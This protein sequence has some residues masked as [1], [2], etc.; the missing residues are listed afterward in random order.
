M[1]KNFGLWRNL[2][3]LID[4]FCSIL[5]SPLITLSPLSRE[6]VALLAHTKVR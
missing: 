5:A 2:E 4:R 3:F 1:G 6:L